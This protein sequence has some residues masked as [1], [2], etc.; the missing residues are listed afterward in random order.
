[1]LVRTLV[2]R[3]R[4]HAETIV[5]GTTHARLA[6]PVTLGHHLLAHAWALGRDLE[7]L[8]QWSV[9]TAV[10][11]LGAGALGT[12]SLGLFGPT[13][14]ERNGPYG[15]HGRGL[16]SPDGT[17]ASLAPEVAMDAALAMLALREA[18]P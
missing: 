11:P 3:A 12:S 16:Q 14:A 10:S 1:M 8:A 17:M 9:R 13:R 15:P 18:A 5:P 2:A 6:Q 7:R 4:E